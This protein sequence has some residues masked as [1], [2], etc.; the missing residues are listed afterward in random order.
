MFT[1]RRVAKTVI[2][3]CHHRDRLSAD[4]LIE[5]WRTIRD[6]GSALFRRRTHRA[7]V[8]AAVSPPDTALAAAW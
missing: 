5:A 6:Q 2:S 1:G 3:F 8:A 7:P 4:S